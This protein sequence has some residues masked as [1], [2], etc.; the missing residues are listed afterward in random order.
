M[1]SARKTESVSG[2]TLGKVLLTLLTRPDTALVDPVLVEVLGRL[3][4]ETVA[5]AAFGHRVSAYLHLQLRGSGLPLAQAAE[6]SYREQWGRHLVALADLAVIDRSLSTAGLPWLSV[7]GA[8]LAETR[9]PRPDLRQ[10]VDLDVWVLPGSEHSAVDA[11]L[12]TGARVV[13]ADLSAVRGAGIAQ[14]SLS[15]DPPLVV[16]GRWVMSVLG[17]GR[18]GAAGRCRC[19]HVGFSGGAVAGGVVRGRG[20]T[21]AQRAVARFAAT[22]AARAR[23]NAMTAQD[24]QAALAA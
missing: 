23:L 22:A 14:V 6:V 24:T 9:Y 5:T 3:N 13:G 7:K 18:G 19:V 12:D 4:A 10:Y 8:V 16:R 17:G 20:R 21:V 15:P 2:P 1:A 11:L